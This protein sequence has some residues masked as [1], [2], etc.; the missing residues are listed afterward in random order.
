MGRLIEQALK[1]AGW[2]CTRAKVIAALEQTNLD[3]K[4]LSGGPIRFTPTDHYGPTW[5]KVSRWN[6]TK[7]ALVPVTGWVKIEPSEIARQ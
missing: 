7:K 6:A 5:W 4:G 1:K 3:T 2:P